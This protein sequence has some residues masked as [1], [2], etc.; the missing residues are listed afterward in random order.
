YVKVYNSKHE[1]GPAEWRRMVYQSKPRM[2]LDDTFGQFDCPDAGQIAPK[3]TS[4]ITALQALNLLNSNFILQQSSLFA[5]RLQR[6]AGDDVGQQVRRAFSLAF[7]RE[8]AADELA[9]SS[10]FIQQ[11][12]LAAFCRAMLNANEFLFVF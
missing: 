3:R 12:G 11:H 9:A 5:D 10:Q 7:L 6:E 1:F 8:P 4:S 2:Q